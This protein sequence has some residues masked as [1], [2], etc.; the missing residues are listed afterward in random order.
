[1]STTCLEKTTDMALNQQT[2]EVGLSTP[3]TS[4]DAT[5]IVQLARRL[6]TESKHLGNMSPFEAPEGGELD[7]NSEKFDSKAWARQFY[8]TLYTSDPTRVMGVAYAD[9]H[10]FGYGSDTESQNTVGNWPFKLPELAHRLMGNRGQ[11]VNILRDFEGLTRPGEM[12]CVLG[13]PGSGCY[14]SY[15]RQWCK[16][17]LVQRVGSFTND[18]T[19][20]QDYLA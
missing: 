3:A 10:V 12:V 16:R 5:H 20:W 9:L 11:K 2:M 18:I 7:P 15:G 14:S 1:M 19:G 17:R 13:P 8:N 6:S 4:D